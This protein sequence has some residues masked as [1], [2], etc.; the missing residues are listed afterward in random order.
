MQS[1]SIVLFDW[2]TDQVARFGSFDFTGTAV[3]IRAQTHCAC[4]EP[5][6]SHPTTHELRDDSHIGGQRNSSSHRY[7]GVRLNLTSGPTC[8]TPSN[9]H[10]CA[11]AMLS[12]PTSSTAVIGPPNRMGATYATIRSITPARRN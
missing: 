3:P 9:F 7:P 5:V 12:T 6:T 10:R 11:W 2:Q 8:S 1:R 4:L